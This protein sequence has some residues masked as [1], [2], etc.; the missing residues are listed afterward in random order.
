MPSLK[1]NKVKLFNYRC[2]SDTEIHFHPQLTVIIGDNG[3]GKTAILDA[4]ATGFGVLLTRLPGISGKN[5]DKATDLRISA[6]KK[7][8]FLRVTIE[9]IE[10]I[11]WDRTEKR[12]QSL[13]T[14]KLIPKSLGTK[15][16]LNF[17]DTQ[18]IDPF[19]ED[20]F[21]TMPVIVY[22]GTGRGVFD[23]PK[24]KTSFQ[25][26]FARFEALT[27]A[28]EGTA[29]F[30]ALFQWIDAMEDRERRGMVKWEDN[31]F[32]VKAGSD[33]SLPELNAVRLAIEKMMPG[34]TN[35]RVEIRPKRF[36]VD[37]KKSDSKQTY[38]IEQ[39]SDG[40]RM[41]LAMVMDI[42]RRMAQ[43]N[44]DRKNILESE[45]IVLID[46]VDLHLHP[47]WQQTI[48][49]DLMRTFPNTQ[50][51][52]TTH[53]PQVLTTVPAKCLRSLQ[54]ETDTDTGKTQIGINLIKS[55]T[56]GTA[57]IDTLAKVMGT[58]P[59]PDVPE[60]R[61]LH[62]YHALIQQNQ[63]ETDDGIKLRTE[64]IAHFGIEHPVMLECER[65]IRLQALKG[66]L[67]VRG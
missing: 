2:F 8:P 55:E 59:I 47:K 16:L 30:H 11:C 19:N 56:L 67:P 38:R 13:A 66:K 3:E 58:D 6:N 39:L 9:T 65:L 40:Y 12:D 26:E 49:P 45:A 54:I 15:A 22:Y 20:R 53:S 29:K 36:V 10:G 21:F 46:E 35:P 63:H 17:V 14:Q 28:L 25:K 52:V 23:A 5:F 31:D 43:A 44:P 50:F 57:S 42:A 4:I 7:Q 51:I 18:I 27:G 60:A 48:L 62:Q 1:L 61:K 34:F 24:N 64:L 41:T 32:W 37:W 33:Q